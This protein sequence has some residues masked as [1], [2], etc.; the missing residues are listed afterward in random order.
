MNSSYDPAN[1]PMY[2]NSINDHSEEMDFMPDLQKTI[3][4]EKTRS[5]DNRLN[6]FM[7]DIKLKI[8]LPI[9]CSR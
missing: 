3:K 2:P 4:V 1:P 9:L 8:N 7:I 6:D 5:K